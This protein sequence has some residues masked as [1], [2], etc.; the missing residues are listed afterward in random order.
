M[1]KN[2]ISLSF[3]IWGFDDITHDQLTKLLDCI[4]SEVYVKGKRKNP[5]FS[6]L[7]KENGWII[8]SQYDKYTSFDIQMNALLDILEPKKKILETIC[9]QYYCEF[10]CALT[11]YADNGE[12]TP[13]VHLNSRYN[14]LVRD[15][16]IEFDLDL[17][18][19]SVREDTSY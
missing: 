17:Y 5:K 12:S 19:F 2:E 10:S 9:K 14:N 13:W 16:N 8:D 4:P 15:L 1:K 18:C 7:A 11:V 6:G 3:C